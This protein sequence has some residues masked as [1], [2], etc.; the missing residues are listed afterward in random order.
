MRKRGEQLDQ[1][2]RARLAHFAPIVARVL[3]PARVVPGLGQRPAHP[4]L[5]RRELGKP[6]VVEVAARVVGLAHAARRPP[7]RADAQTLAALPRVAQAHDPEGQAAF[8]TLTMYCA[9]RSGANQAPENGRSAR[10]SES[11]TRGA[12]SCSGKNMKLQARLCSLRSPAA[13]SSR[14]NLQ[15]TQR[16]WASRYGLRRPRSR[17]SKARRLT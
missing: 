4:L 5:A 13:A 6:Q 12:N 9:P 15:G 8:C 7:H 2:L 1:A 11:A 16:L 17:R 10:L 3:R 14:S